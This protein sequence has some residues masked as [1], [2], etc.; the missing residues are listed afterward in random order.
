M[1]RIAVVTSG[2]PRRSETFALNEL[3]GLE[4]AG[5]LAAAF[6]TKPGDGLPP[7]PDAARLRTP[8]HVL[9]AGS[10]EA[11]G[12]A[13]AAMLRDKD[14]DAVHG[15][16]AHTPAAVAAA[17][18]R[19]LGV[20]H[21]FSVHARDARKPSRTQ[22]ARQTEEA[23]CVI[24]CNEDVARELPGANGRLHL[25]PHGVDLERFRP[26]KP[27]SGAVARVLA[28]GRLVEK[29]GFD[30]FVEAAGLVTTPLLARIIGDGPERQRLQERIDCAQ[31]EARVVLDG[32]RTH[33]ELAREYAE[34]DL[35]VVPSVEDH[36]GDRDGLPNVVLEAM[37][38]ARAVVATRLGAIPSAIEHAT[39]GWLVAPNDPVALAKAIDL[40]LRDPA[41][42]ERIGHAG[43]L[44][45]ER[46]FAL[47]DCTRR[48]RDVLERAYG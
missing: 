34:S 17:A 11:Q 42:R 30:V 38:S 35:V 23:T 32:G 20:R 36:T 7:H 24:A 44:K 47:P 10:A 28:V 12:E 19:S 29:K 22:L 8:V 15:Y 48:L 14:V 26:S 27:P 4:Q 3:V 16:F 5:L 39:T 41:L 1:T 33:D 13:V 6:A 2:F 37:G 9:P 25:V 45:A 21:G 31:L 46:E 18:A 40:L 43:R